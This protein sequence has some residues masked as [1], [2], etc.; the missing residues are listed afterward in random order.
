MPEFKGREAEREAK[1][2]KELAPYIEAALARKKFMP[3]PGDK[4]IPLF[5]ALGRSIAEGEQGPNKEVQV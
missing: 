5:P 2:T 4:D 3:M 1:K